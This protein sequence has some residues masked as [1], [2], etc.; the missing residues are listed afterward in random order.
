MLPKRLR[1]PTQ[2]H[3]PPSYIS[4]SEHRKYEKLKDAAKR[5]NADDFCIIS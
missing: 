5:D 3:I 1:A 4:I 2:Q